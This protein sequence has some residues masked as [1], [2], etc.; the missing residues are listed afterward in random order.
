MMPGGC[1]STPE[2]LEVAGCPRGCSDIL[3]SGVRFAYKSVD[4]PML[5]GAGCWLKV[6]DSSM[7]WIATA[8]AQNLAPCSFEPLFETK[9][10]TSSP[11]YSSKATA[12]PLP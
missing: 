1:S 2:G 3:Q 8:E 7:A 10:S 12:M 5:R 9:S 11:S 6:A 4:R